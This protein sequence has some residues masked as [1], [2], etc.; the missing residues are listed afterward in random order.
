M[1]THNTLSCDAPERRLSA[2]IGMTALHETH[3]KNMNKRLPNDLPLGLRVG[4]AVEQ[5]EEAIL[6]VHAVQVDAQLFLRPVI[7]RPP[8]HPCEH[9]KKKKN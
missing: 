5:R 2:W 1:R 4:T 8:I 7:D 9:Q 6:R 3:L